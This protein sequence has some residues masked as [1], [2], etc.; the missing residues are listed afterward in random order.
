MPSTA[1]TTNEELANKFVGFFMDKI[2]K[3]R[4]EL[5]VH[6]MYQ[7]T[8]ANICQLS[9]VEMSEE[10]VGKVINSMATKSSKIDPV[11]TDLLKKSLGGIL[12][13]IMKSSTYHLHKEYLLVPGKQLL[14]NHFLRI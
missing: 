7:P 13:I 2:Q 9:F 5:D 11:P 4:D 8:S 14:Y 3:I 6:P 10:E 12:H 1:S